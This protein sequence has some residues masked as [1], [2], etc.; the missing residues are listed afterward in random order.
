M[1]INALRWAGVSL[2]AGLLLFCPVLAIGAQDDAATS[3][4]KLPII[5]PI[6]P[7]AVDLHVWTNKPKTGKF[8]PGEAV[9]LH[10][11]SAGKAFVTALY[12]SGKGD[13]T[14]LF[15]NKENANSEL[16]PGREYTLVGPDSTIKINAGAESGQDKIVVYA[17]SL[18]FALDPLKIA[19]GQ[20]CLSIP[21]A[22]SDQMTL[23]KEKLLTMSKDEGFNY[24]IVAFGAAPSLNLMGLPSS[25]Q[26]A[27]PESVAGVQGRTEDIKKALPGLK[28][29]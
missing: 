5:G 11:K 3:G 25:V 15:P 17:S 8:Q 19:E 7:K 26:S 23:L 20:A 4:K 21:S 2:M 6:G 29:E 28:N 13:V 16:V 22:A 10:A 12:L 14:V 9:F 24:K 18:P 1:R 27:V